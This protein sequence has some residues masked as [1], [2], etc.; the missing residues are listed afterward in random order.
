MQVPPETKLWG[1][2]RFEGWKLTDYDI[3][4]DELEP[5]GCGRRPLDEEAWEE[6]SNAAQVNAEQHEDHM[7]QEDEHR[8]DLNLLL[9][10]GE[11]YFTHIS[12]GIQPAGNP[13]AWHGNTPYI[14]IHPLQHPCIHR[15]CRGMVS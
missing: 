10:M 11:D 3:S 6:G 5:M 14:E 1:K 9:Q 4:D 2:S 8:A 7:T 15:R 12:T 13:L